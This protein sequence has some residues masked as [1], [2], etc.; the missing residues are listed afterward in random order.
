M[1]KLPK[2]PENFVRI[3]Q[4]ICHGICTLKFCKIFSFESPCPNLCTN[5]GG[6]KYGVEE[7]T[8]S[9][10]PHQ[11]LPH[12]CYMLPI[13]IKK[14]FKI[15]WSNLNTG[16]CAVRILPAEVKWN[17]SMEQKGIRTK[18]SLELEHHWMLFIFLLTAHLMT[19]QNFAYPLSLWL[20]NSI[21]HGPSAD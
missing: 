11:I 3:V 7:W 20:L 14:Y 16:L 9:T 4:G 13:G 5:G 12:Q 21:Y 10:L 1:Q 6:V 19:D 8:W 15:A 17:S 18:T 2:N